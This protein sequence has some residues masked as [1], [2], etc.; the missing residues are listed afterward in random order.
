M[1]LSGCNIYLPY[2]VD[3]TKEEKLQLKDIPVVRDTVQVFPE[4]LPRLP[5]DCEVS[6]KIELLPGTAPILKAPYRMAPAKLKELQTQ[7]R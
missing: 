3:A 7:L 5:L 6:F 1:M 4:E 2:V